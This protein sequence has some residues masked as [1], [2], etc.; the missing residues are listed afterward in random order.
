MR[1]SADGQRARSSA[2]EHSLHT[3]GVTGSIPVAP[4]IKIRDLEQLNRVGRKHGQHV[5]SNFRRRATD[6]FALAVELTQAGLPVGHGR[7]SSSENCSETLRGPAAESSSAVD[8]PV[9]SAST[10]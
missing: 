6:L 2:G 10:L 4:T 1:H 3:G 9:S 5:G 7:L 8:A